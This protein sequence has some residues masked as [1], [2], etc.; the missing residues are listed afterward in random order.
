MK[1]YWIFF[2][3]LAKSLSFLS[4]YFKSLGTAIFKDSLSVSV[5]ESLENSKTTVQKQLF[6][7]L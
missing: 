5:P 6:R 3:N 7:V 1:S 4:S 2:K